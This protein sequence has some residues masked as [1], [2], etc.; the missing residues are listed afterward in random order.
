MRAL[1]KEIVCLIHANNLYNET[2]FAMQ[3]VAVTISITIAVR[4]GKKTGVSLLKSLITVVAEVA[5]VYIEM[6]LL[7][8][9]VLAVVPSSIPV[10][11]TYYNN[12]GRTFVLVPISAI[13][14]A[15]A[16]KEKTQKLLCIFA[17]AQPMIWGLASIPCLFA[18]CCDGLP[19]EWGLYNAYLNETLFPT[20]LVN[21]ICLV[22]I[23]VYLMHRTKK[24]RYIADGKEYPIA[25]VLIGT[26][27]FA[28]EFLMNNKK[29]VFGLSSLSFDALVMCFVGAVWLIVARCIK[30][31]MV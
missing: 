31:K 3:F 27:R 16:V 5:A 23:A 21:A 24:R 8:R 9:L 28:T 14:L 30:R 22:S 13:L 10:M 19:C 12:V 17:V 11:N 2:Y 25:L 29:I 18:G 26:V 6:E 20:Q 15:G 4:F 7:R 1:F